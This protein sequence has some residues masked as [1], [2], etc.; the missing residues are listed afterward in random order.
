MTVQTTTVGTYLRTDLFYSYDA[1]RAY[2]DAYVHGTN[3]GYLLTQA[4]PIVTIRAFDTFGQVY[5]GYNEENYYGRKVF[6]QYHE[7]WAGNT[8]VTAPY[9]ADPVKI[10]FSVL[11]FENQSATV[12]QWGTL[13]Y[14]STG[15]GMAPLSFSPGSAFVTD[16]PTNFI[17]AHTDGTLGTVSSW[18]NGKAA[19]PVYE[20]AHASGTSVMTSAQATT[21]STVLPTISVKTGTTAVVTDTVGNLVSFLNGA[22][23]DKIL[24]AGIKIALSSGVSPITAA[25]AAVILGES[26]SLVAGQVINITDVPQA[27]GLHLA[28]L[29]DG[30]SKIGIINVNGEIPLTHADFLSSG[31]LFAKF[32]GTYSFRVQGATVSNVAT[33]NTD[34]SVSSIEIVDT[35]G[36]VESNLISLRAAQGKISAISLSNAA[37]T[38]MELLVTQVVDNADLLGSLVDNNVIDVRGTS[39]QVAASID[40]LGRLSSQI[41]SV[42]LAAGATPLALTA[43]QTISHLSLIE[44]ITSAYSLA[45]TDLSENIAEN[46]TALNAQIAKISTLTLSD[47]NS[48][49]LVIDYAQRDAFINLAG[50]IAWP[51][52]HGWE[53]RVVRVEGVTLAQAQ[54]I[55]DLS[56]T[57]KYK[58]KVGIVDTA[59]NLESG[60]SLL[61]SLSVDQDAIAE[62]AL[63]D[64][65]VAMDYQV[66]RSVDSISG[67]L[68]N[69]LNVAASD[70]QAVLLDAGVQGITLRDTAAN[71]SALLPSLIGQEEKIQSIEL[72]GS[73]NISIVVPSN[74]SAVTTLYNLR[75]LISKF[76]VGYGI[77]MDGVSPYELDQILRNNSD[78]VSIA[79]QGSSNSLGQMLTQ[80]HSWGSRIESIEITDV[81]PVIDISATQ[82]LNQASTLNKMSGSFTY[83]VFVDH[84]NFDAALLAQSEAF[85]GRVSSIWPSGSDFVRISLADFDTYSATLAKVNNGTRFYLQGLSVE[86]ALENGSDPLVWG[87]QITDTAANLSASFD[88]LQTL[89][90]TRTGFYAITITQSDAGSPLELNAAQATAYGPLLS[91][92]ATPV[93]IKVVDTSSNISAR[94]EGL[95]G[96]R[97]RISEVVVSD[98]LTVPVT[99]AVS[100]LNEYSA[101]LNQFTGNYSFKLTY[102][103]A[104]QAVNLASDPRFSAFEVW[105]NVTN[106]SANLDRLLALGDKLSAVRY[107][108]SSLNPL[109]I[110]EE[111]IE[112]YRSV[113]TKFVNGYSLDVVKVNAGSAASLLS[114]SGINRIS[115]EDT[116]SNIVTHLDSLIA[117]TGRIKDISIVDSSSMILS[118][119]IAYRH[120]YML[121]NWVLLNSPASLVITIVDTTMAQLSNLRSYFPTAKFQIV[122]TSNS[123]AENFYQFAW[124]GDSINQ[125]SLTDNVSILSMSASRAAEYKPYI[126]KFVG[127]IKV[128]ISDFAFNVNQVLSSLIE[129]GSRLETINFI[130][131]S[132]ALSMNID[133]FVNASSTLAK[134]SRLYS[135]ALTGTQAQFIQQMNSLSLQAEKIDSIHLVGDKS[136]SGSVSEARRYASLLAKTNIDEINLIDTASQLSYLDLSGVASRKIT[137]TPT[138]LDNNIVLTSNESLD[139]IDLSRL[140]GA[141]FV[142]TPINNG[143]GVSIQVTQNGVVRTFTILNEVFND[144]VIK[145]YK[146]KSDVQSSPVNESATVDEGSPTTPSFENANSTIFAIPIENIDAIGISPDGRYL[147]I[148]SSGLSRMISIG[149]TLEFS[150]AKMSGDQISAQ[151]SPTPVFSSF[152]NGVTSYVLPDL[153]TGPASL[154]LK[155]QLIDSTVNAIV[156]GSNDNDFIKVADANSLGKAVNGGGGN[157]VID[158]GVGSTFISG[159]GGTNIFFLDGRAPGVSWSTITDFQLGQDKVT[160]WGWKQGVSKV[161]FVDNFGGAIGYDGLTLH[162]ENLLPSNAG[163]DAT[164]STWNS[165]TLSGRN[166]SDLG[167]KSLD[168]L[169][170]QILNGSN[171]FLI[172]SQTV[173]D[174]GTHGYLHIS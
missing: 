15:T 126:D 1:L 56:V 61:R 38:R 45:I 113:L 157:D 163:A 127:N 138:A 90:N 77:N 50:K 43:S 80:I 85:G 58:V 150:N 81:G 87:V 28:A 11:M 21:L 119:T 151:I 162:F 55:A 164:N 145:G 42:E 171:P 52:G 68:V 170:A 167:A 112:L 35:A 118:G 107:T 97:A 122:D 159:G 66:Y 89:A 53:N 18:L 39:T 123:V 51:E 105:D 16:T 116:A 104:T 161:A 19:N 137:L 88:D 135:V 60:A 160:I 36:A 149:D 140:V 115:V 17:S 40:Q 33:L 172:T 143:Y 110:K 44:K 29:K 121:S 91:R 23:S 32:N 48:A 8:A 73:G 130:G 54:E 57:N 12:N 99:L 31:T 144:L 156:T 34:S 30:V 103:T 26:D 133:T 2:E 148:K 174:F 76:A 158:G 71:L 134:I 82:L 7:N 106:I 79:V 141:S 124:Y 125:V 59:A 154:G 100:E 155:Y 114:Q 165:I 169:N 132:S 152:V 128:S 64:S 25:N 13:R 117:N 94:L 131:S 70:A 84:T 41:H 142:A 96:Q 173:D 136:W 67:G 168:D 153:F 14:E 86:E 120:A 92:I 4:A 129:L 22:S 98:G 27:I 72:S 9:R 65:V 139:S 75:G 74:T 37:T 83:R 5:R 108:H 109:Q 93:T 49:P 69:V 111:E 6:T 20:I 63:L 95:Y 62:I 102:A 78:V 147:I 101:Q 10:R 146:A 24:D 3:A 46:L 166:L 47:I